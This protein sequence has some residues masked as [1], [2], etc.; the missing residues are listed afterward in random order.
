MQ[1][2]FYAFSTRPPFGIECV[3]PVID[4]GL[5]AELEYPMHVERHGDSLYLSVGVDN[6]W[7]AL[8]KLRLSDVMQGCRAGDLHRK[9]AH[10]RENSILRVV[11]GGR[12]VRVRHD[13]EPIWR[14]DRA[15][16]QRLVSRLVPGEGQRTVRLPCKGAFCPSK[17]SQ[18]L[19]D[20]GHHSNSKW[21]VRHQSGAAAPSALNI[22]TE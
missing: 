5:S 11:E 16:G 9:E 18:K 6:C 17:L 4:L 22:T 3:T 1:V 14:G 19:A 20:L 21:P 8:V 13:F 7:S 10:V 12:L 2:F 15:D